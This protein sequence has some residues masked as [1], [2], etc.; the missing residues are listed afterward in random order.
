M[1]D[2]G[3]PLA[4]DGV[5][6]GVEG[7]APVVLRQGR[8]TVGQGP[9]GVA[10]VGVDGRH[11]QARVLEVPALDQA[12]RVAEGAADQVL[13]GG[14]GTG[15]GLDVHTEGHARPALGSADAPPFPVGAGALDGDVGRDL[16]DELV[17]DVPGGRHGVPSVGAE[18]VPLG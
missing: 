3:H 13:C 7:P 5:G 18:P 9:V 16:V 10:V 15:A 11:P 8:E 14:D 4:R 12:G 2:D 17:V 1:A 6:V